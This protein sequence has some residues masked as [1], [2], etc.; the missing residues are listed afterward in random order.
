[1]AEHWNSETVAQCPY[2]P[3]HLVPRMRFPNHLVKCQKNY[4]HVVLKICPYN[5]THRIKAEA[6]L[7]HLVNCPNRQCIEFEKYHHPFPQNPDSPSNY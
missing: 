2:N 1:M 7:Q 6:Y 3:S 5:A 4:P